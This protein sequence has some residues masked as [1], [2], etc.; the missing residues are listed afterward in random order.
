MSGQVNIQD[1]IIRR[2]EPREAEA[3]S[4]MMEDVVQPLAYYNARARKEELAKYS[5]ENL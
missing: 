2:L 1:V 3:I 5:P 4:K